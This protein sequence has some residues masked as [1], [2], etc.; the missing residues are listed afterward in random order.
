MNNCNCN[1]DTNGAAEALVILGVAYGVSKVYQK[2]KMR[3]RIK[4]NI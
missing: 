1:C 4:K 3:R 2:W